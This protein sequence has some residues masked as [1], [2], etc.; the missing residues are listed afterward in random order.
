[1][2][3]S[4]SSLQLFVGLPSRGEARLGLQENCTNISLRIGGKQRE[5]TIGSVVSGF[6]NR[7]IVEDSMSAIY[8]R[9]LLKRRM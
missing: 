7:R 6:D 4:K 8:Q 3:F 1:M 5:C 9:N 2:Y